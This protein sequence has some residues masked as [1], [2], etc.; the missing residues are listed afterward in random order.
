M[1]TQDSTLDPM[2]SRLIINDLPGD[3]IFNIII[4]AYDT[5]QNRSKC[6]KAFDLGQHEVACWFNF[7]KFNLFHL[8]SRVSL[9][10]LMWK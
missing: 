3:A 10:L 4:R 6:N 1:V 8:T 2:L 9:V 7:E 5:T